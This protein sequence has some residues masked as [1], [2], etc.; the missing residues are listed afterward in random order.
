MPTSYT[1]V[2]TKTTELHAENAVEKVRRRCLS[3][4]FGYNRASS[5]MTTKTLIST[6]LTACVGPINIHKDTTR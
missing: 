2:V 6:P 1:G 5:L 4:Y 3:K